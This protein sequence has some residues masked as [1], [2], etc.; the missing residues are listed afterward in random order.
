MTID[1]TEQTFTPVTASRIRTEN[2]PNAIFRHFGPKCLMVEQLVYRWARHLSPEYN[3]GMWEYYELS[4][5]GFYMIPAMTGPIRFVC[6]GNYCDCTL[7]PE[8]FGIVICLFALSDDRLDLA[9][10]Y[11]QLRDY[12]DGHPEAA[13][14]YEAID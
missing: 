9:D 3:G 13:L 10:A 6:D 7:S 11:W 4:N 8:A 2:M 1:S 14:I 12:V 5:G